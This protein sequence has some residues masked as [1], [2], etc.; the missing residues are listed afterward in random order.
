[1]TD[2]DLLKLQIEVCN[3]NRDRLLAAID[4]LQPIFPLTVDRL[5]KMDTQTL[6][7]LDMMTGR[8]AKLQDSIGRKIFPLILIILGEEREGDTFIDRLNRLEKLRVID[9]AEQWDVFRDVRNSIA[10]DYP[11]HPEYLV[12]A[13]N[14]CWEKSHD[15]IALWERIYQYIDLKILSN[16]SP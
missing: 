9:R 6:G 15:L 12:E 8:F 16:G 4:L 10:H 2:K 14:K 13:I 1:M 5:E 11:E 7:L 3:K